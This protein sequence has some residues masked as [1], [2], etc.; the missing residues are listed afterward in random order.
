M[1]IVNA[2]PDSFSDG[3]RWL[4]APEERGSARPWRDETLAAAVGRVAS[5][6]DAGVDVVDVGGES[7]RPGSEPVAR[8]Q[9]IARVVPLIAALGGS[10]ATGR[11]LLSVD[12]RHAGVA[13]A[14][15][16]AG[17]Q[18]IND[19]SGLA[20]PDMA[21]VVARNDLGLVIGHMRGVP[22]TMMRSTRFDA[23]FDEVADELAR[24]VGRAEAAGIDRARIMVDP[25]VGFGKDAVDSAALTGM[26]AQLEARLGL[27]VLIGAS[28]KR[29]VGAATGRP[30][31]E[32]TAG[33][34]AA[35]LVA[36]ERGAAVVRVHDVLETLD[37]RAVWCL[38]G[39]GTARRS[40]GPGVAA[41][42][43]AL[44]RAKAAGTG[45]TIVLTVAPVDALAAHPG[46]VVSARLDADV[47][48][49]LLA[50]HP[51][52]PHH[53]GAVV[54]NA[55]APA[56]WRV[57]R[58]GYVCPPSGAEL[59][60]GLGTRHR[61][62]LGIT[63]RSGALALVLSGSTG[64]LRI[65]ETGRLSEPVEL[66]RWSSSVTGAVEAWIARVTPPP[67]AGETG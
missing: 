30:V 61:G 28:R 31:G 49:P 17:A 21:A 66:D 29:F 56:G 1:A 2:T 35:A 53:D 5:W 64:A 51:A 50:E 47:L 32:R 45:A 12:T 37:A 16:E 8:D 58:L 41:V 11:V 19:V 25:C 22:A 38:I 54:V 44:R 23:L 43:E 13:A 65:A 6:V 27:P 9:E 63:E 3:G 40:V 10:A 26:V 42:L 48:A 46:R 33:S 60:Q 36:M 7:T 20:D 57:E 39:A 24:S 62:A 52:H 59:P 15:A 34:L 14:A 4:G 18:V 55:R 67:V